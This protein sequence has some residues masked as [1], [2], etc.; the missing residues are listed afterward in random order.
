M[1]ASAKIK[2]SQAQLM[3]AIG[4]AMKTF[5]TKTPMP[6]EDIVAVLSYTTGK[7]ISHAARSISTTDELRRMAHS[8]IDRG[9]GGEH[10]RTS[11]LIIMPAGLV[12]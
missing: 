12:N 6:L 5:T 11:E 7:A 3:E 8:N 9:I 2:E 4:E 1:T 10:K